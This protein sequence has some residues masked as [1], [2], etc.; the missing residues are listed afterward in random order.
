MN[1]REAVT[2]NKIISFLV[3]CVQQ[4]SD[5]FHS[6]LSEAVSNPW[7]R[8]DFG[9]GIDDVL[10]EVTAEEDIVAKAEV[11]RP[12]V[13]TE[14]VVVAGTVETVKIAE[15][16]LNS[17]D[18]LNSANSENSANDADSLN[19]SNG[20]NSANVVNGTNSVNV[21]NAKI[22]DVIASPE[23]VIR[24]YS[25]C[26]QTELLGFIREFSEARGADGKY[27][28]LS[29]LQTKFGAGVNKLLS[30]AYLVKTKRGI[31]LGN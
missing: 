27:M 4:G 17:T 20:A 29:E 30:G 18:S 6:A 28:D 21:E 31:V 12:D 24:D 3:M 23:S 19:S 22:V 5:A 11:K 25:K 13:V 9:T 8:E 1:L 15:N 7:Y 10:D 2:A 26:S 16:V 14:S